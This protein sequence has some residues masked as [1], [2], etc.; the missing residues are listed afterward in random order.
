M[1]KRKKKLRLG[2]PQGGG[3][4]S[5]NISLDQIQ[6]PNRNTMRFNLNQSVGKNTSVGVGGQVSSKRGRN[7][8]MLKLQK[9]F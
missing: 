2:L 1:A 6:I 8:V 9:R 5:P 4:A 3:N 7:R